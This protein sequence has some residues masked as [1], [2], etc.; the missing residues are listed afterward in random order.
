MFAKGNHAYVAA[1]IQYSN[2]CRKIVHVNL[3]DTCIQHVLNMY[4]ASEFY[5]KMS[6]R[7]FGTLRQLD[8]R[9][10]VHSICWLLV[11]LDA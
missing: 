4:G 5:K 3:L 9:C 7:Y 1:Y 10:F 8:T 11:Q 6:C 2:T